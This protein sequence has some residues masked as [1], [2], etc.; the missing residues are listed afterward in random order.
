MTC[1]ICD[2]LYCDHTPAERGQSV[3]EMFQDMFSP[4]IIDSTGRTR[5]VT[6]KEYEK[7]TGTPWKRYEIKPENKGK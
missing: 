5:K 7:H 6:E 4:H 1:P 2:R 3:G